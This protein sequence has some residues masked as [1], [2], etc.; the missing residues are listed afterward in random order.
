MRNPRSHSLPNLWDDDAIVWSRM[1]GG[2]QRGET[3]RETAVAIFDGMVDRVER[4]WWRQYRKTIETR[5][6]Q[7]VIIIRAIPHETL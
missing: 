7:D 1:Q 6:R 2:K 3:R 5:F 4:D